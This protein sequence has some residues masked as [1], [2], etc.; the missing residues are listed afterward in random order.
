MRP[1]LSTLVLTLIALRALACGGSN[2]TLAP[3]GDGG[4][5]TTSDEAMSDAMMGSEINDAAEGSTDA[6]L[7]STIVPSAREA[8]EATAHGDSQAATDAE[9]EDAEAGPYIGSLPTAPTMALLRFANWSPDA[10]AFDMCIAPHG[11]TSFQGPLLSALAAAQGDGGSDG[12]PFPLVSAYTLVTPGQYD[13]R[14]VVGGAISCAV[15]IRADTTDLPVLEVGGAETVALV[16][17]VVPSAADYKLHVLG[18]P[19]DVSTSGSTEIRVINAASAMPLID[20][21]TGSLSSKN[22]LAIFRGVQVGQASAPQDGWIPLLVD[23]NGYTANQPISNAKLSAHA[24]GG[25]I[26]A[27]VSP[28]FS[29]PSGVVMTFVVAGGT[30]STSPALVACADNAGT[31]GVLSDCDVLVAAGM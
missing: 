2:S 30:S 26:D 21:G 18:F 7:D 19:D 9:S 17:E 4:D 10:P 25:T 1:K 22:F 27:V 23:T 13:A 3:A 20:L 15:G 29:V 12:L 14:I 8:G 31:V 16:G 28:S 5:T 6:P 11:T 24:S